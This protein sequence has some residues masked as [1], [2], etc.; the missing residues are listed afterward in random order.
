[1]TH[2][3]NSLVIFVLPF[4]ALGCALMTGCDDVIPL[5]PAEQRIIVG[6]APINVCPNASNDYQ[7]EAS[8]A[9]TVF[10]ADGTVA[11]GVEVAFTTTHGEYDEPVVTTS[12]QKGRAIAKLRVPRVPGGASVTVTGT[13]PTTGESDT[14]EIRVPIL[15]AA[16][17]IPDRGVDVFAIGEAKIQLEF[18]IAN[19][20]DVSELH[21][22]LKYNPQVVEVAPIRPAE[23][24]APDPDDLYIQERGALNAPGQNEI[25]PTV[26][27][28]E[29]TPGRL[30]I[31]YRR[32]DDPRT[33]YSAPAKIDFLWI[34]FDTLAGGDADF[35]V[36]SLQLLPSDGGTPWEIKVDDVT[37]TKVSVLSGTSGGK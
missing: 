37:V 16:A 33:G 7:G 5:K 20:C 14:A 18:K 28:Y 4:L 35:A 24:P 19:P 23:G 36:E 9:A 26:L 22:V 2:R 13:V 17:F 32:D 1:M 27:N 34:F 10:G 15:P 6:A 12:S 25:T 8:V 31:D 3:P 29:R 30:Q 11:G 21:F